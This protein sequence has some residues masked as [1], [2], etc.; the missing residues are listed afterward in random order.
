MF[1]IIQ[2]LRAR[3]KFLRAKNMFIVSMETVG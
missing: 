2:F 3:A 1:T